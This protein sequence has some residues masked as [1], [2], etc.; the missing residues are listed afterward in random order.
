M[1]SWKSEREIR[2]RDTSSQGSDQGQNAV[3]QTV[4]KKEEEPD[5]HTQPD[6][7]Q[8]QNTQPPQPYTER[9]TNV[10]L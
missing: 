4:R 8:L 9:P 6:I 2:E 7:H 1:P 10:T 5:T 3:N